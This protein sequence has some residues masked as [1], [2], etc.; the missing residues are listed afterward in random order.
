M[1]APDS[2]RKPSFS[3]PDNGRKPSLTGQ[4]SGRRSAA[5]NDGDN[6]DSARNSRNSL[7]RPPPVAIPDQGGWWLCRFCSPIES[8]N[9]VARFGNQ[10][11]TKAIGG[12]FSH[13]TCHSKQRLAHKL[14]SRSGMQQPTPW[15]AVQASHPYESYGSI[16]W[17]V[18]LRGGGQQG[19]LLRHPCPGWRQQQQQAQRRAVSR[20]HRQVSG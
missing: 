12:C 3:G 8:Q 7:K 9:L 1:S 19:G 11:L 13:M 17:R 2:G 20:T 10:A 6:Q 4:D 16:T 18:I 14:W 15:H 5:S